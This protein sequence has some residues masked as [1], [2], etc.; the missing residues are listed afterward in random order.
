MT[1]WHGLTIEYILHIA[2]VY[3]N[4]LMECDGLVIQSR[5]LCTRDQFMYKVN[6]SV[7]A[8]CTVKYKNILKP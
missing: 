3:N 1:E 8:V 2:L 7:P 6:L 5:I 4:I